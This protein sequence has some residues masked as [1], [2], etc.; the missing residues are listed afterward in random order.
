MTTGGPRVEGTTSVTEGREFRGYRVAGHRP[1]SLA[2]GEDLVIGMSR[3][4]ARSDG[5][6]THSRKRMLVTS[7]LSARTDGTRSCPVE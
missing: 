6:S 1:C 3:A 7:A 2:Y 5:D 4:V